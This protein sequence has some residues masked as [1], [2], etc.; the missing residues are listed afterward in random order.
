[1]F[2]GF[3][4]VCKTLQPSYVLERCQVLAE[5]SFRLSDFQKSKMELQLPM[6]CGFTMEQVSY[7]VPREHFTTGLM[8]PD[9]QTSK[10]LGEFRQL[11]G[12]MP[13]VSGRCEPQICIHPAASTSPSGVQRPRFIFWMLHRFVTNPETALPHLQ[14]G[15][16]ILFLSTSEISLDDTQTLT[17]WKLLRAM[18]LLLFSR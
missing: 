9:V 17:H 6:H 11:P 14:R 2:M 4:S 10:L 1:M 7:E 8:I 3:V 5:C 16:V 18:L 13:L 12:M 15:T